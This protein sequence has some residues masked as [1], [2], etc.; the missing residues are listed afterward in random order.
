MRFSPHRPLLAYFQIEQELV[1]AEILP[2]DAETV[3]TSARYRSAPAQN[4]FED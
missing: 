2:E 1:A 3:A 4:P